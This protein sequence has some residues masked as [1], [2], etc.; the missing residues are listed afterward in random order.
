[1]SIE[2]MPFTG[3]RYVSD[4]NSAQISYEHWHRYLYATQFIKDKNVLDIACGEGYGSNL[5]AQTAKTVT[6]ID[7]SPETIDFA[8][9]KYKKEN[10]S[11]IEGSVGKIPVNGEKVFDVVVSFETIEHVDALMQES[12]LKEVK[13]LLKDDGIF[14][15]SSPNKLFYSDIPNYKNEFHIKEFYEKEFIEFL[16][17]YFKRVSVLGQKV[18]SGSNM[19]RLDSNEQAGSFVEYKIANKEKKFVIDEQK[20]EAIYMVAVCSD[21]AI[22]TIDNS[23]LVDTSL[24]LLSEKN[25]EISEMQNRHIFELQAEQA[26]NAELGG[27][28]SP[29]QSE[30]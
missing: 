4:L 11:F 14:I 19:W 27:K 24:G 22:K 2:K 29:K 9:T 3:E 6:G 15:V 16:R 13:R 28:R 23:V 25:N 8:K 10:L 1:M 20:K 7:I 18:I 12:F 26:R 30:L 17:K 5:L 21:K